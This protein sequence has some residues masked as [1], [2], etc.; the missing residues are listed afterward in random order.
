MVEDAYS[1]FLGTNVVTRLSQ[2]PTLNDFYNTEQSA[3]EMIKKAQELDKAHGLS[4]DILKN[5]SES[6]MKA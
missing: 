4:S 5:N 3:N 2:M 1:D 6:E